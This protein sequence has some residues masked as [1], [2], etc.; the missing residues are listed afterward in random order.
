MS[1][2]KRSVKDDGLFFDEWLKDDSMLN[3]SNPVDLAV[4]IAKYMAN[5]GEYDTYVG[6][7]K[8]LVCYDC[9]RNIM[10]DA[11][12]PMPETSSVLNFM[13]AV[14][15]KYVELKDHGID[16][17]RTNTDMIRYKYKKYHDSESWDTI[18]NLDSLKTGDILVVNA[19]G[20]S[21]LHATMVTGI[22]GNPNYGNNILGK[23][24][25][26]VSVVHDKGEPNMLSENVV[27]MSEYEWEDLLRGQGGGLGT[28]QKFVKAY[29]YKG[30]QK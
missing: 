11:G 26:G 7:R 23:F 22:S 20:P 28:N 25:S 17:A 21:G 16:E 4:T 13:H 19:L 14:E 1:E 2:F 24:V 5:S 15:G 12:I 27:Q 3:Q 10:N 29:R 9:V 18:E 8:G 30:G 6:T